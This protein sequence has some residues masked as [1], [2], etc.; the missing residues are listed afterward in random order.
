MLRQ[1]THRSALPAVTLPQVICHDR[2]SVRYVEYS[3]VLDRDSATLPESSTGTKL[4]QPADQRSRKRASPS[5][6]SAL[7]AEELTKTYRLYH[8]P[9]LEQRPRP[10]PKGTKCSVGDTTAE[11]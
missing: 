1:P 5:L 3:V 11:A 2:P 4:S 6:Y 7:E 10:P 9:P 8:T